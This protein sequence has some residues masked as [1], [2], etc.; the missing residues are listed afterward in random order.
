MFIITYV[1]AYY[2][3]G[4][5]PRPRLD[6]KRFLT[7]EDVPSWL[8]DQIARGTASAIHLQGYGPPFAFCYLPLGYEQGEDRVDDAH[9]ARWVKVRNFEPTPT[10]DDDEQD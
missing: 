1:T 3:S 5:G 8:V 10:Q 9:I 6:C 2:D 7:W 4:D